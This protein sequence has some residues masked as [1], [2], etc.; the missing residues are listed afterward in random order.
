[1]QRLQIDAMRRVQSER[2]SKARFARM[3]W[4]D[5]VLHIVAAKIGSR[6]VREQVGQV[7]AVDQTAQIDQV[8]MQ[9]VADTADVE[10]SDPR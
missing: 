5:D 9:V 6:P 1:V 4:Q 2:R 8:A 10:R 3:V 7:F